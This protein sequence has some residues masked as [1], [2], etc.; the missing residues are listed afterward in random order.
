M[1]EIYARE[2]NLGVGRIRY[3]PIQSSSAPNRLTID[4]NAE[5][6]TLTN[7]WPF[8]DSAINVFF[9]Q[10]FVSETNYA[11]LSDIDG[12]CDKPVVGEMNGCVVTLQYPGLTYYILAHEV[13]HY[14]GLCHSDDPKCET[15]SDDPNNLMISVGVNIPARIT[16]E[17]VKKMKEHCFIK[18]GCK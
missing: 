9:V 6:Y 12:V 1:R 8:D 10:I 17:Q 2:A 5:A 3:N 11:G 18:S 13:G 15:K 7:E 4:N 16:N 14:L